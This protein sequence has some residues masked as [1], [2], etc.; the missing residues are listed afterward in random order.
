VR[1]LSDD[2][3]AE[4]NEVSRVCLCV[5]CFPSVIRKM[6]VKGRDSNQYSFEAKLVPWR[7]LGE[8]IR[9]T[10]TLLQPVRTLLA[11]RSH[12]GVGALT[13]HT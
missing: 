6:H 13:S 3:D 5:L 1:V 4:V 9:L 8:S 7:R 10:Q 2:A 11:M 12:G